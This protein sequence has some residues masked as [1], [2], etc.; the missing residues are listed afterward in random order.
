MRW[1]LFNRPSNTILDLKFQL[2]IN[3]IPNPKTIRVVRPTETIY[4]GILILQISLHIS[5]NNILRHS[6]HIS[7]LKYIIRECT[8][9]ISS[10][11]QQ[12]MFISLSRHSPWRCGIHAFQ[13]DKSAWTAVYRD[14]KGIGTYTSGKSKYG[15]VKSAIKSS[16]FCE[17]PISGLNALDKGVKLLEWS[18]N[19][20]Q[21]L[22][23]F[24]KYQ[25]N[26][27]RKLLGI[28]LYVKWTRKSRNFTILT[29]HSCQLLDHSRTEYIDSFFLSFWSVSF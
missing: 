15:M 25:C 6:T 23:Y 16:A 26:Q 27:K 20:N 7:H 12:N 8:R 9:C 11:E 10:I 1:C 14:Y 3:I 18:K 17:T 2:E 13:I 5:G 19:Y 29:F 24:Y 28:R 4:N 22:Y 21:V